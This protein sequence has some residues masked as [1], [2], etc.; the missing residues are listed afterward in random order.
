MKIRAD[1][2]NPDKI[3]KIGDVFKVIHVHCT[4]AFHTIVL[5]KIS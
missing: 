5:E 1:T 3:P 2:N 4:G